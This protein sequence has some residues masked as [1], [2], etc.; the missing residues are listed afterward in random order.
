M[1]QNSDIGQSDIQL[2][3]AVG[4]V[5]LSRSQTRGRRG[6]GG[7][8]AGSYGALG[9]PQWF[10]WILQIV[11]Q[12]IVAWHGACYP[13]DTRQKPAVIFALLHDVYAP[14]AGLVCT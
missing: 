11:S 7:S 8:K 9:G 3:S 12:L 10:F 1:S 4:I 14:T 5:Y 6:E 13:D 2:D